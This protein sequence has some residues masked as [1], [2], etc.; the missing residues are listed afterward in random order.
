[1]PLS[2]S[3]S[4]HALARGYADK[5][6][7]FTAQLEGV[8]ASTRAVAESPSFSISART[9]SDYSIAQPDSVDAP[10]T[11]S[12]NNASRRGAAADRSPAIGDLSWAAG[13][14][15]PFASEGAGLGI[16]NSKS[17]TFG[18]VNLGNGSVDDEWR[19]SFDLNA[20][21]TD[22]L[23]D[24]DELHRRR[25]MRDTAATDVINASMDVATRASARL[26]TESHKRGDE[27]MDIDGIRATSAR[28]VSGVPSDGQRGVTTLRAESA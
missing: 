1:M 21:I 26:R 15:G 17:M 5:P 11:A 23:N 22:L 9:E 10:V 12:A 16:Q 25:Q 8:A 28:T 13:E 2:G 4:L 3:Q 6:D 7:D 18:D 27:S 19:Q 20:A 24:H 14:T